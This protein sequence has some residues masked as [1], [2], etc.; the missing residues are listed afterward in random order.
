M[1]KQLGLKSKKMHNSE[2]RKPLK[3]VNNKKKN[4]IFF[5][6]EIFY[7]EIYKEIIGYFIEDNINLDI[8]SKTIKSESNNIDK[9]IINKFSNNIPKKVTNETNNF[10]NE[11]VCLKDINK[12]NNNTFDINKLECIKDINTKYDIKKFDNINN[13]INKLVNK[14][15]QNNSIMADMVYHILTDISNLGS[16]SYMNA[17]LHI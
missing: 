10:I 11:I 3:V 12:M 13:S 1:L 4:N 9:Q 2:N 6:N 17:G 8:N 15:Y 7:E 14:V 5:N 16:T